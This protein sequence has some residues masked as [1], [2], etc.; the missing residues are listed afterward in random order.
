MSHEFHV[1]GVSFRPGYPDNIFVL[2]SWFMDNQLVNGDGLML[3]RAL[4]VREPDNRHDPNAIRV[5]VP[6]LPEEFIG[7]V[8]AAIAASRV[9]DIDAG[10]VNPWAAVSQVLVSPENPSRPGVVL[11]VW[12]RD[13]R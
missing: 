12:W 10:L 7:Y 6:G 8:P 5:E 1:A 2:Q 4:L 11:K 3:P 13:E 9:H